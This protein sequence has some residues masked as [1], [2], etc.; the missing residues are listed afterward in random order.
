M[1]P[2]DRLHCKGAIG[3]RRAT[4]RR[5]AENDGAFCLGDCQWPARFSLLRVVAA[6]RWPLRAAL[7][8]LA[9]TG[10]LAHPAHALH[11]LARKE[12]AMHLAHLQRAA[13][14]GATAAPCS[15]TCGPVS[16]RRQE[17]IG[18]VRRQKT[19][20]ESTIW[21]FAWDQPGRLKTPRDCV[22]CARSSCRNPSPTRVNTRSGPLDLARHPPLSP[23]CGGDVMRRTRPDAQNPVA[24]R[25]VGLAKILT[26][27]K[28]CQRWLWRPRGVSG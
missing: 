6:G 18:D 28:C 4:E 14:D 3:I 25:A 9:M 12:H 22:T 17:T 8:R 21:G 1:P 2:C 26:W 27:P 16:L 20:V 11:G 15:P 23:P 5:N 19:P 24:D 13:S 10:H 7:A